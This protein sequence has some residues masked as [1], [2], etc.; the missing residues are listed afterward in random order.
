MN[1]LNLIL[2]SQA[3]FAPAVAGAYHV[4]TNPLASSST[5]KPITDPLSAAWLQLADEISDASID[6]TATEAVKVYVNVGGQRLVK[7]VIDGTKELKFTF[8]A[9]AVSR[10]AMEAAYGASITIDEDFIPISGKVNRKGWLKLQF[11][12]QDNQVVN[13]MDAWVSLKLSSALSIGNDL[14]MPTFECTVLYS[15]LNSGILPEASGL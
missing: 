5:Y 13:V 7:D 4:D 3:Y 2:R 6:P 8:K 11:T 9:N 15:T 14:V 12:A 1:F 10:L